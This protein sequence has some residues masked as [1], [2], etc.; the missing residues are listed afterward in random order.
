MLWIVVDMNVVY[1]CNFM[2]YNFHS[3]TMFP[4]RHCLT[5]HPLIPS[6]RT[7]TILQ[8]DSMN[9]L[10]NEQNPNHVGL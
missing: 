6:N 5:S 9:V 1:G 7:V 2:N 3:H 10:Y 8:A 4:Q